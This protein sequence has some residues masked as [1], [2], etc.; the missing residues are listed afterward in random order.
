MNLKYLYLAMALNFGGTD[1]L[2]GV[3]QYAVQKFFGIVIQNSPTASLVFT[4]IFLLLNLLAVIFAIL[5]R[6]NQE[7]RALSVVAVIVTSITLTTNL[8]N[9]ILSA[10]NGGLS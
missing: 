3:S 6:D 9:V 8:L 10:L 5:S 4:G 1:L 7:A 2:L